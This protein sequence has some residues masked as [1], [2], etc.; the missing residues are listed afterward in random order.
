MGALLFFR[1]VYKSL[2]AGGRSIDLSRALCWSGVLV[3]SLVALGLAYWLI[4][5]KI[6]NLYIFLGFLFAIWFLHMLF[7][8]L[9]KRTS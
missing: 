4:L 7:I 6:L 2:L 8:V 5:P 9:P 3:I 1:G